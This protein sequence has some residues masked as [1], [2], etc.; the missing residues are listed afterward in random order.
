MCGTQCTIWFP[1]D[2]RRH[3]L[4]SKLGSFLCFLTS[5]NEPIK[6]IYILIPNPFDA[7]LLREW[8]KTHKISEALHFTSV[9]TRTVGEQ[10][11]SEIT[12]MKGKGFRGP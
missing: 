5:K 1:H 8:H 4:N 2:A 7:F 12:W 3:A 6:R 9:I 10:R 11:P